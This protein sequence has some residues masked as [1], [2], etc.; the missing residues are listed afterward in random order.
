MRALENSRTRILSAGRREGRGTSGAIRVSKRRHEH[1]ASRHHHPE[2]GL[3]SAVHEQES[4]ERFRV[5]A[6]WP[7]HEASG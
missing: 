4:A 6:Q 2:P 3:L 7:A 5:I 1:A